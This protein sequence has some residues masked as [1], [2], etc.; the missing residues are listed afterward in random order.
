VASQN[1]NT[2]FVAVFLFC[3]GS[4]RSYEWMIALAS[5]QLFSEQERLSSPGKIPMLNKATTMK[6]KV[7]R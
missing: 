3:F 6:V 7:I 1:K 2:I 4:L 5:W